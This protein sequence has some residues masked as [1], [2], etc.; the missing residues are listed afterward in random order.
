MKTQVSA[1]ILRMLGF[2]ELSRSQVLIYQLIGIFCSREM[3]SVWVRAQS[4]CWK[5]P[6][7]VLLLSYF[8]NEC[9]SLG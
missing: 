6:S 3:G 2:C 8:H 9:Q 7:T 4:D 1:T 5:T